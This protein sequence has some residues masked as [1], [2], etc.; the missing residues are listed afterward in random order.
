MIS[1]KKLENSNIHLQHRRIY[2]QMDL[3]PE[4][5]LIKVLRMDIAELE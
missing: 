4:I 2:G 5:L 3:W 1:I